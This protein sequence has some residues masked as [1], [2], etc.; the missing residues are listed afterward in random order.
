MTNERAHIHIHVNKSLLTSQRLFYSF[1]YTNM[2]YQLVHVE[3]P[4]PCEGAVSIKTFIIRIIIGFINQPSKPHPTDQ[5]DSR[6]A[7]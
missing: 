3:C 4:H 7:L 6:T 5:S 2:F 1:L